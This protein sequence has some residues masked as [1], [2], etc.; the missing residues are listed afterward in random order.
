MIDK[1]VPFTGV[2]MTCDRPDFYP[3]CALPEGYEL[4]PYEPG[5]ERDWAELQTEV[6]QL[7]SVEAA[8]AYFE[9]D[10]A[11]D[12]E[13]L[14]KR[15]VFLYNRE[16]KLAASG[17]L[18]YGSHFG[19]ERPRIRKVAVAPSEQGK[20]LCKAIMTVLMDLYHEQNLSGGIYL[21]SQTQ[22]YKAINIYFQFGFKSYIGPKP[23]RFDALTDDFEQETCRAWNLIESHLRVYREQL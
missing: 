11:P 22:S 1:T 7:P 23:P 20:G 3:N 6:D 2:I 4:R 18:W 16:G 5:M 19:R 13:T 10:F 8:L 17:I 21:T 15:G 9:R 12:L 14:R